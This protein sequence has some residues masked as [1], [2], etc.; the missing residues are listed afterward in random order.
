MSFALLAVMALL[1]VAAVAYGQ[2]VRHR[3]AR[4]R[5][6]ELQRVTP[7]RVQTYRGD[8]DDPWAVGRG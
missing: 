1:A 5:R 2:H 4:L 6:A 8:L 7:A 3:A